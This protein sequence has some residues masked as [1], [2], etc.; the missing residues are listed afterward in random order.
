VTKYKV[1]FISVSR[2]RNYGLSQNLVC[3][4][5]PNWYKSYAR[6]TNMLNSNEM[7]TARDEQRALAEVV[8]KKRAHRAQYEATIP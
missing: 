3:C 7:N 6:R 2:S 8:K 5:R 1:S 4:D